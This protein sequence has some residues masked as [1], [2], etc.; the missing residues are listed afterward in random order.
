MNKFE[1]VRNISLSV[2]LGVGATA[3]VNSSE[4]VKTN[5]PKH[6]ED[7]TLQSGYQT[8]CTVSN[9]LGLPDVN[10]LPTSN[11]DKLAM[12]LGV[13]SETLLSDGS[14]VG[15]VCTVGPLISGKSPLIHVSGVMKDCVE[16]NSATGKTN[17]E[18]T[19]INADAICILPQPI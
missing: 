8:D 3:C 13:S 11:I 1:K 14:E 9:T 18:V 6:H 7:H 12:D 17:S 4:S 2:A 16:V 19:S 15:V 10:K 5:P